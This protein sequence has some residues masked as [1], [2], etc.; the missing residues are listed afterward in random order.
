MK[1]FKIYLVDFDGTLI[2]SFEGLRYFYREI[3]KEVGVNDI[4]DE[5][6]Y[7]FTKMS[8]QEAYERKV[9]DPSKELRE[10]FIKKCMDIVNSGILLDRNVPFFDTI[11]FIETLKKEKLPNAIVTGNEA[12]HINMVLNNLKIGPYYDLIICSSDLTYQKPHPEGIL[13]ALERMGYKGDKKDVCYIGD[14]YNDFLAAR[15]AGVTPIMIDRNNEY[16]ENDEYII[17]HSLLDL[18]S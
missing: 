9:K 15:D 3:F 1:R 12:I 17:I 8:L 16:K 4:S 7:L 18:F 6:C 11:P 10:R 2:N 14:A 5:D 13:L